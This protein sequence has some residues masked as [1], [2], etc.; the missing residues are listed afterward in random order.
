MYCGHEFGQFVLNEI[1]FSIHLIESPAKCAIWIVW[2]LS[3]LVKSLV[4]LPSLVTLIVVNILVWDI[5]SGLRGHEGR[6]AVCVGWAVR[7]AVT[8]GVTEATLVVVAC[9]KEVRRVVIDEIALG[10]TSPVLLEV[11]QLGTCA[12][13]WEAL[14][15]FAAQ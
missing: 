11:H 10:R 2:I 8:V 3:D 13:P 14:L 6:W 15:V 7:G 1:K 9:I 4:C 12:I 5:W